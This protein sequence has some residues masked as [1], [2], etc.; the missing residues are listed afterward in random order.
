MS[1][2]EQRSSQGRRS[3]NKDVKLATAELKEEVAEN[4]EPSRNTSKI[5]VQ[6]KVESPEVGFEGDNEQLQVDNEILEAENPEEETNGPDY[7]QEEEQPETGSHQGSVAS[8]ARSVQSTGG[9]ISPKDSR[10]SDKKQK[11][12]FSEPQSNIQ[13]TAS[14]YRVTRMFDSISV[15][16]RRKSSA[17]L[18]PVLKF[19]PSYRLESSN[20]FN[21]STVED[22][23]EKFVADRMDEVGKIDFE[24]HLHVLK[25]CEKL[26]Y[27][28]LQKIKRK[29]YDRYKIMVNVTLVEKFHQSFRK[30][31]GCLWDSETDAMATNVYDRQDL[32]V[33]TSVFGIY[34][35]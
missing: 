7:V 12:V 18:K 20:P 1:S 34:Y 29:E 30:S 28:I 25:T 27:D 19:Q 5:S 11:L 4:S 9:H 24:D 6:I 2:F 14:N 32:F 16:R 17:A 15:G 35:D 10:R 21:A 26:S 22:I 23:L 13:S 3:T 8:I 31:I 33:I